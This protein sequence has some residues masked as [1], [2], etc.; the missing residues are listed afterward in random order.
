MSKGNICLLRVSGVP[1]AC[2]ASDSSKV[3]NDASAEYVPLYNSTAVSQQ[4]F[5]NGGKGRYM[6]KAA[7]GSIKHLKTEI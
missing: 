4:A 2:T 6:T 3:M 7:F 1:Q 5:E